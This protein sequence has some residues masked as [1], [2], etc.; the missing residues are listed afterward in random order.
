M[1]R[2]LGLDEALVQYRKVVLVAEELAEAVPRLG[3]SFGHGMEF[4]Q[5]LGVVAVVFDGLAPFVPG[6]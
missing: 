6:G 4:L 5:K 3:V 1:L 2:Q